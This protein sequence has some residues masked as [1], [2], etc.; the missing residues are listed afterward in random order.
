MEALAIG[1]TILGGGGGGW[2]QDGIRDGRLALEI[3]D[4]ELWSPE[5]APE[6][7]R[8]AI[9]AALGAPTQRG[10][11]KPYHFIRS[12]QLICEK[13]VDVD[14]LIAA[15][16]GGHNSFGGWIPAAALGLPIVDTPGYGRTHPSAVMGSMGLHRR[17]YRSIKTGVTRDVE[18]IVSGS[19]QSTS[20]MIHS[21]ARDTKALIA[22]SRDPVSVA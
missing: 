18:V 12:V 5:E 21:L 3:G 4:I 14:G 16:N 10:K 2:T 22:M 17:E 8:V 1:G 19:L 20:K 15:E 6:D 9:T 7:W 13:G 11:M